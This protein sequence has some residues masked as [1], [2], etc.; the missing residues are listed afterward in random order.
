MGFGL[1]GT[2]RGRSSVL[3]QQVWWRLRVKIAKIRLGL[4]LAGGALALFFTF[5]AL[6]GGE[7]V[8]WHQR[9]TV[10]VQTPAGEVSGAAVTAITKVDT[11]GAWVLPEARGVRSKIRGEAVVVEIAP[12]KY[13]FALLGGASHWTYPAFGLGQGLSY[14]D[15]MDKLMGIPHDTPSPLPVED[16]PLLVTFADITDPATVTRVDPAN[17]AASFGPGVS[18][19][20]VTLAVTEDPVTEG[21]VEGVLGWLVSSKGRIKKTDK[22][23]A[24]ELTVEETLYRGDFVKGE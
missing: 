21:R 17:L 12:G 8:A 22:I 19:T 11:D 20:S 6:F 15:S 1:D 16:Y 18:L 7:T 2:D 24:D 10:T 3:R 5:R 14:E 23:Y 13:L 9:L 4:I